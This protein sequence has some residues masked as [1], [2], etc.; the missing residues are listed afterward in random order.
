MKDMDATTWKRRG[1]S[2]VWSPEL[3]GP[4]ITDGIAATQPELS[5]LA[6]RARWLKADRHTLA[7]HHAGHAGDG[8]PRLV[9]IPGFVR[10][11]TA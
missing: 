10:R 5:A 11:S 8:Q 3:L 1:S 7:A 4:L 2:I 9:A 6:F